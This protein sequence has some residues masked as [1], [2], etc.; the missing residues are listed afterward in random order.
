MAQCD[1]CHQERPDKDLKYNPK[2]DNM[3][4]RKCF[5]DELLGNAANNKAQGALLANNPIAMSAAIKAASLVFDKML[6]NKK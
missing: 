3:I 4:C 5:T 6:K 2:W 1:E